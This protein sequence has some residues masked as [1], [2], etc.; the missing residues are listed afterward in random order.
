MY[1]K[2][3]TTVFNIV[4]YFIVPLSHLHS[5]LIFEVKPR[6]LHLEGYFIGSIQASSNLAHKY[7][8]SVE[9][10]IRDK[11]ASLLP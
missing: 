3:F 4:R 2:L 1:N 7:F 8:T 5:S 9:M 11:R 6:N 10:A